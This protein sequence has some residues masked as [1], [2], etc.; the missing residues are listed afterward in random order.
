MWFVHL[1]SSHK[2]SRFN[3]QSVTRERDGKRGKLETLQARFVA[4]TR[5]S[6][7]ATGVRAEANGWFGKWRDGPRLRLWRQQKRW[8][9]WVGASSHEVTQKKGWLVEMEGVG[10]QNRSANVVALSDVGGGASYAPDERREKGAK[11]SIGMEACPDAGSPGCAHT[12]RCT[13][14]IHFLYF[15]SLHLGSRW[16]QSAHPC[17]MSEGN[18]PCGDRDPE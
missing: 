17:R 4:E 11:G 6:A 15:I 2:T 7:A 14:D 5:K 16:G 10:S 18:K 3:L 13:M 9:R 1:E 12:P 8:T